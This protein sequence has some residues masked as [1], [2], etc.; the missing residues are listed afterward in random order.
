LGQAPEFNS[1]KNG[2]LKGKGQTIKGN[3]AE[4]D[5]FQANLAGEDVY[6]LR[7]KQLQSRRDLSIS[8][9]GLAAAAAYPGWSSCYISNSEGVE[10]I[11][12][13]TFI[14]NDFITI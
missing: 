3:L 12:R 7:L 13:I 5:C 6:P 4:G 1:I 10:S 2:K 14:K 11:P 8:S 9:P